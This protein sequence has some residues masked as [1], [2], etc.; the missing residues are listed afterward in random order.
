MAGQRQPFEFYLRRVGNSNAPWRDAYAFLLKAPW[1]VV[2]GL[3][4]VFYLLTNFVFALLYWSIPGAVA[5]SDGS[6]LHAFF[7]SV[8]TFAAIGYGFMYSGSDLSNW[9][10]V[11]QAFVSLLSIALLTGI[12]FAKFARPHSRVLFSKVALVETR[13]GKPTLTFRLA[14]ERGNDVV[15]ASLRVNVLSTVHTSE[16]TTMRRFAPLK[17]ERESSPV[18]LLSWQVFHVIDESSPLH[19]LDAKALVDDDVRL[20]VSLTGL[21]GTFSQTIHARHVYWSE[22]V[23]FGHRFEDVIER[24]PGGVTQMD[25]RKFHDTRRER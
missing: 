18:F 25:F 19:G 21:D 4:A 15:E 10:V 17:L 16:G 8:Q 24:L 9:V 14:N 3:A 12:V 6:L 23:L 13:D 20:I 22:D 11:V 1:Y 5:N 2:I 7:F